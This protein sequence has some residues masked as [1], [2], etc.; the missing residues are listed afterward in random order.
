MKLYIGN[1]ENSMK[2]EFTSHILC[3]LIGR[4]DEAESSEKQKLFMIKTLQWPN[5]TVKDINGRDVLV[6]RGD[7]YGLRWLKIKALDSS[8][9]LETDLMNMYEWDKIWSWLNAPA[10][11]MIEPNE[12]EAYE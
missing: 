4:F 10:I 1:L 8:Y 7:D 2:D 9:T 6:E 3:F 5:V 11:K 12:S